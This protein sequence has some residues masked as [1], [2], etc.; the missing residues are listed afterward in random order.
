MLEAGNGGGPHPSTATWKSSISAVENLCFFFSAGGAPRAVPP[1]RRRRAPELPPCCTKAWG[2]LVGT[3]EAG[4]GG[5]PHPSTATWK[6][7]SSAAENLCMA[8]PVGLSAAS[9]A[10]YSLIRVP[11]MP[12][13]DPK[14][15]MVVVWTLEASNGKGHLT[16][17][18]LA[19][20]AAQRPKIFVWTDLLASL[21]PLAL[22]IAAE[23]SQ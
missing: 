2:V 12:P 16:R 11:T 9:G 10:L 14:V 15:W 19:K 3:L 20:F 5:D 21:P 7:S 18:R 22:D 6:S 17:R 13:Y 1:F 4:N 23:G 8:Q